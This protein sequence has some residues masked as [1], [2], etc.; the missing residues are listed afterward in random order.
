MG[1]THYMYQP[2]TPLNKEKWLDMILDFYK[3]LPNFECFLDNDP[4]SDQRIHASAN[5]LKFNGIGELGH[6]TF[7]FERE[8]DLSYTKE[9]SEVFNFC[10]TARKPYDLAVCCS[11]IIAKQHFPELKV[12]SDG[13]LNDEWQEAIKLTQ[14]ILGYGLDFKFYQV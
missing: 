14:K 7:Y 10:K 11:L 5:L 8:P 13:D 1:Y 4:K 6:E 12:S 9:D 2:K 3:I